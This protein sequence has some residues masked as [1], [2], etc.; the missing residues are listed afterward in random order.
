MSLNQDAREYLQGAL[1]KYSVKI[2]PPEGPLFPLASGGESRFYVDVKKTVLRAEFSVTLGLLL[3]CH[4]S[5]FSDAQA[6]AGVALGGCHLASAGALASNRALHVIHVRKEPKN[7]GT[8]QLVEAPDLP[9]GTKIVLF[10]DVVTTGGSS[11]KAINALKE[12]GFEVVGII[13]IVDRRDQP[14]EELQGYPLRALFTLKDF[15]V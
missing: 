2:A 4:L 9:E 11:L 6:V 15:D 3:S 12:K 8:K 14:T 10:E 7:H 13:A 5:F 1:K